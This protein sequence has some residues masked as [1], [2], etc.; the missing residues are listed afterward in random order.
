MKVTGFTF[1]RNA[2]LYDYPV[3]EAITSILPVCDEFVVLVGDSKD[4]TRTLI[5]SIGSP[6]IRIVDSVW[7]D[8]LREGGRVLAVETDKAFR[9]I[10]PDTTWAFYI[11]AD[12]VVH[13]QYLPAIRNAMEKFSGDQSVEGLLFRYMH[14]Y[15]SYDYVGDSSRWYRNEVRVVRFD[16]EVSSYRDAQGF[17]KSGRPLVVEPLAAFIYHYGWVKP[18]D[19]QQ[20]KQSQFHRL[21][22]TDEE[23]ASIVGKGQSFDYSKIDSLARF[24]GTHP[25]VMHRRIAEKNW[26]FSHDPSSRRLSL[27]SRFKMTVERLTGWRVG[28]YRNYRIRK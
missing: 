14:F 7:D 23:V 24:T 8:T 19:K 3:V 21:W 10:R 12:E 22:H 15:G 4:D 18:P 11:Q 2:V 26:T 6:K 27:K 9:E 1:V 28:E 20:A 13:E 5:E 25:H 16:S 17:R